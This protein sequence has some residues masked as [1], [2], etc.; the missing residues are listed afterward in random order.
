MDVQ[1]TAPGTTTPPGDR[2]PARLVTD[3]CCST[4]KSEIIA[5][6]TTIDTRRHEFRQWEVSRAIEL[7]GCRRIAAGPRTCS[8]ELQGRLEHFVSALREPG[9]RLSNGH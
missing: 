8:Y 9:D 7:V 5:I 2:L 4:A 3:C 6:F 1:Q